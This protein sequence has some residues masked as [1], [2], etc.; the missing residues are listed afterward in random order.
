MQT[1]DPFQ[2]HLDVLEC[3]VRDSWARPDNVSFLLKS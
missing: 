3:N 1:L 2:L